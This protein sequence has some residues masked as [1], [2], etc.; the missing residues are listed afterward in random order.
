MEKGAP[1]IRIKKKRAPI[2]KKQTTRQRLYVCSGCG[3]KIRCASDSLNA[4]HTCP[5]GEQHPF[6]L[7]FSPHLGKL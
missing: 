4:L 1:M 2:F 5:S 6:I 7:T 3:Q